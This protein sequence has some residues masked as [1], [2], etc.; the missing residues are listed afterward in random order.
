MKADHLNA[1][2]QVVRL[3]SEVTELQRQAVGA[4]E[5]G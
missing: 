2:R 3:T 1:E 5:N 4:R